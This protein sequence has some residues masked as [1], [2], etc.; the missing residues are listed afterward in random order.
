MQLCDISVSDPLVT[1]VHNGTT[2]PNMVI[3]WQNGR[4]CVLKDVVDVKQFLDKNF[5]SVI[6]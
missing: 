6:R 1:P 5:T 3:F 2:C 4:M